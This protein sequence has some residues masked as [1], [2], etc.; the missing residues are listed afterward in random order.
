MCTEQMEISRNQTVSRIVEHILPLASP[1][2]FNKFLSGFAKD[3]HLVCKDRFA[4]HVTQ[5]L[6][7]LIPKYINLSVEDDSDSEGSDEEEEEELKSTTD[8]FLGLCDLIEQSLEEFMKDTY[9]SHI[10]RVVLEILAGVKVNEEVVRS[11]I[12]RQQTKG[13]DLLAIF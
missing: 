1:R 4:S 6:I 10:V 2:Q 11:R 5:T 13:M 9:A 3:W 8:V 12:S 7:T